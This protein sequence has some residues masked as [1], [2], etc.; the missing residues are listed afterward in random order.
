MLKLD[1]KIDATHYIWCVKS[2]QKLQDQHAYL[3]G[4]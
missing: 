1:E 2:T 3:Q 4:S